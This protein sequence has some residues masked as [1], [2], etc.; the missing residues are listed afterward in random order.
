[1]AT[2]P[3]QPQAWETQYATGAAQKIAK[4]KTKKKRQKTK[5]KKEE[6]EEDK[7]KYMVVSAM[8]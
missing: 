4:K 7:G 1:M 3:I 2:A 5:K 8:Y 6:E